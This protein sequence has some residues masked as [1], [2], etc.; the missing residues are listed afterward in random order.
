MS[1]TTA[2]SNRGARVGLFCEGI[3]EP[4]RTALDRE[5]AG[6]GAAVST[7][8]RYAKAARESFTVSVHGKGVELAGCLVLG[9]SRKAYYVMGGHRRESGSGIHHGAGPLA[10]HTAIAEAARRGYEVFDFEGS[11]IPRVESFVRGFGGALTPYFT[12][13]KAWLPLECALKTR[14]RGYF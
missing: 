2:N 8:L 3:E 12:V 6:G 5:N 14:Y 9:S 4:Q 13:A 7:V 11:T 1:T 10:L